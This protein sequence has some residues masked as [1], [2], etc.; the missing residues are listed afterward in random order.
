MKAIKIAMSGF[1]DDQ[2][3]DL[4]KKFPTV[5]FCSVA[6]EDVAI[7]NPDALISWTQAPTAVVDMFQP[8][9]LAKYSSLKWVHVSSAGID[10]YLPFLPNVGFT[11]TCGKVIQGTNVGDHGM[12]LLLALTRRLPWFIRGVNKQD[13]PRPTELRRK[14]ALIIGFGGVGLG[15]AERCAAFGMQ[16]DIV[17]ETCPPLFSFI[18]N[19]YYQDQLLEALPE[20][21]VVFIAAPGTPIT[22]K[23]INDEALAAMKDTAYLINVSRGTIVDLDALVRTL[24]EGRLE[25]VGL[26]VTDPE[27]LPED[28][29]VRDFERVLITPHAAGMTTTLSRRLELVDTNIHRFVNQLPLINVVDKSLGF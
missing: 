25:A 23:M 13:V 12:A 21:D 26:D 14:R 27:P 16:I 18:D 4:S 15:L 24:N 22:Y 3:K 29:P 1:F 19:V 7:N 17:T 8:D 6:N 11:F 20:A 10:N 9:V 5:E 2:I 28:H